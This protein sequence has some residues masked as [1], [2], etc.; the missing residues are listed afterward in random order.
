MTV[1]V[2][3]RKYFQSLMVSLRTRDCNLSRSYSAD[4]PGW[5]WGEVVSAAKAQVQKN[6]L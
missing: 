5:L 3:E 4:K 1:L 2:P 6:C